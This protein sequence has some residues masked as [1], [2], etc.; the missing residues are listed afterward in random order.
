M[1]EVKTYR[2]KPTNLIPNSPYVLI[3]Y[4]GL[5]LSE[6]GQNDFNA[7]T[8][9]DLFLRN[10]WPTRWIAK[11]GP[12]QTSHYHSTAHECM[13]VVSGQGATIRFGAADTS[14]DEEA[15]THGHAFEDGGI[16]V[17][18]KLGDVFIIPA[19]VA[20]KTHDP[21]PE[22]AVFK[23]HEVQE[24]EARGEDPRKFVEG[25]EM[26][27]EFMMIGAYPEGGVWDFAVGGHDEGRYENVWSVPRPER[28]PVLGTSTKGICGLWEEKSQ[29]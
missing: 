27:G 18:A 28:D 10:G 9:Y 2:L 12:T 20:H 23:F 3:H 21:K 6:V 17:E 8:V 5:L 4:P 13:A 7:S 26:D 22:G 16:E 1:V 11:Y 19:G 15:N 25:V 14:E 29:L 24:A